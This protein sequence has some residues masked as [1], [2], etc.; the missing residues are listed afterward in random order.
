MKHWI[1]LGKEVKTIEDAPVGAIGF[2]YKITN[3]TTGKYYI[4]KKVL[5]NTRKT[6]ISNRTR[7]KEGSR[8]IYK[9]VTNES[10]WLLYYGSCKE[11]GADITKLG[12]AKFKREIIEWCSTK[13]YLTFTEIKYQITGGKK[14]LTVLED[15]TYNGNILGRYFRKD[16]VTI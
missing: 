12:K 15:D 16:L 14:C 6:K 2:V 9:R 5:Y 10:D 4:G 1:Y 11:L 3:L 8:K 7:K 13:K